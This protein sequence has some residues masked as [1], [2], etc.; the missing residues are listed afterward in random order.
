[1]HVCLYRAFTHFL[2]SFLG[3]TNITVYI[4]NDNVYES[5]MICNGLTQ[6]QW[7]V[8]LRLPRLFR[9]PP[10]GRFEEVHCS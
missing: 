4:I 10:E 2:H 6:F 8:L 9:V 3:T 7:A 5:R 1:M